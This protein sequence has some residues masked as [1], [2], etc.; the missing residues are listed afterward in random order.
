[1]LINYDQ[2]NSDFL[3]AVRR[4]ARRSL[5]NG[6][7]LVARDLVREALA[8]P[9]PAWYLSTDYAWRRLKLLRAGKLLPAPGS[10]RRLML[11]EL[12]GHLSEASRRLPTA[13]PYA[14]LDDIL[15]GNGPLP[16]RFFI[17]EEY[18][19]RLFTGSARRKVPDG[20]RRALPMPDARHRRRR[21]ASRTSSSSVTI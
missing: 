4:A 12:D 21:P 17:S 1:M 18:A 19:L 5:E 11:E 8:L 6:S 9:A 3:R 7:R 20:C 14:L 2:R 15:S 10:L 13:D 16:S